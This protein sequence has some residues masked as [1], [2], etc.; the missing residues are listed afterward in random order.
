LRYLT[1]VAVAAFVAATIALLVRDREAALGAAVLGMYALHLLSVRYVLRNQRLHEDSLLMQME[2]LHRLV[3]PAASPIDATPERA[4]RSE[5]G[6]PADAPS[7]IDSIEADHGPADPDD[8][9]ASPRGPVR[10][11]RRAPRWAPTGTRAPAQVPAPGVAPVATNGAHEPTSTESGEIPIP[12]HFALG[13][14]ALIRR[15]LTPAEVA[16]VLIEQRRQPDRR[17]ATLAVEMR[18]LTDAQ[19]EEL[20][21]AQQEGLFTEHEMREARERLREFRESTAKAMSDLE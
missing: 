6:P 4:E 16:R 1:I 17:F 13:T 21:L 10:V 11:P 3:D 18:L 5:P 15:L 12:R 8:G 9:G 14:V 2:L 20:L 19:R 7:G